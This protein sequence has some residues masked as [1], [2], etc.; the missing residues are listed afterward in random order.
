MTCACGHERG[1]HQSNR[2]RGLR[3]VQYGICLVPGCEC[4]QYRPPETAQA[5]PGPRGWTNGGR[6]VSFGAVRSQGGFYLDRDHHDQARDL[7]A[8]TDPRDR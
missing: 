1:D 7:Q 3:A 2:A 5:A 6:A 4:R 8:E